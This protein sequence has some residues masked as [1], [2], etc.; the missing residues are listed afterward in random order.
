MTPEQDRRA[1]ETHDA[2]VSLVT[3]VQ[4]E[5]GLMERMKALEARVSTHE[6]FKT[7]ALVWVSLFAGAV[8]MVGHSV[9]TWIFSEKGK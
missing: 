6:Q 9:V 7:Q 4:G 8:A 3:L 5:N 2:V 1:Q